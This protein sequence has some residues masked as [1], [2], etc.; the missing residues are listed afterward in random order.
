MEILLSSSLA[1]FLSFVAFYKFI[2][3]ISASCI[4]RKKHKNVK[5]EGVNVYYFPRAQGFT[6]IPSEGG[7]TLGN[8]YSNK[9][10]KSPR[11]LHFIY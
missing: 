11:A 10:I 9:L 2:Y 4:K 6:C 7:S 1:L 5:F 8:A 3:S